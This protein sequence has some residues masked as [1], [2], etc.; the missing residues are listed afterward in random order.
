MKLNKFSHACGILDVND[1]KFL[2]QNFN[3]GNGKD[4]KK[5]VYSYSH[6]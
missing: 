5:F 2:N 4:N 3:P 1:L 6:Y